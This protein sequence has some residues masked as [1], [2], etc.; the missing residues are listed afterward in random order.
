MN[1]TR[2]L[3]VAAVVLSL[4]LL[5]FAMW[6]AY[7]ETTSYDGSAW[8]GVFGIYALIFAAP[9]LLVAVLTGVGLWL[10]GRAPRVAGALVVAGF[11]CACVALA[12]TWWV[13]PFWH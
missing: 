10:R 7:L 4:P 1:W 11:A 13:L 3:A 9:V 6:L 12:V 8:D 5:G 2:W